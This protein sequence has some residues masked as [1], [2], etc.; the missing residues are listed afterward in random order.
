[1]KL[2]LVKKFSALIAAAAGGAAL[3]IAFAQGLDMRTL[4]DI[5]RHRAMA[6]AHEGAARCLE[7]GRNDAVCEGELQKACTGIAI[8]KYCGM[9]HEH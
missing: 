4:N 5:G 2:G 1:M 7:L 8:G 6:A 9:K 3:S